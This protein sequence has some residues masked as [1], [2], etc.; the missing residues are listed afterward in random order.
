MQFDLGAQ[1]IL[2]DEVVSAKPVE[3]DARRIIPYGNMRVDFNIGEYVLFVN[4][5]ISLPTINSDNRVFAVLSAGITV[6]F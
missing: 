5:R 6:E 4:E 2:Y 1:G 3:A